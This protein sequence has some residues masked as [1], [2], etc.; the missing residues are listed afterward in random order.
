MS[1]LRVAILAAGK[2]TRMKS[3]HPKV[4]FP[5]CGVPMVQFVLWEA[6]QLS[7]LKPMVVIGYQ[8]EQVAA[9][10]GEQ[11]EYVWQREQLGT[12]D[13]VKKVCAELP[14]FS[15]DLLVL[16]GDTPFISAAS[17]RAMLEVHR[18]QRAAATVLTAELPDPTGY[19]RILRSPEGVL[20]GIVEEKDASPDQK[21]IREVN[22][23]IYCF[24]VPQLRPALAA[25]QPQ[26]T[27]GEYYLTDVIGF[28]AAAGQA[29][30]TVKSEHPEE[31]MGPNDRKALA[32]TE[33]K[34]RQKILDRIME[35]GVTV[36]DPA[37]TYIDPRVTI[38]RDTTLYPGVILMGETKIGANC[39][40]GPY[41]QI[42][43]SV[44]GE[45]SH[46]YFSILTDVT[47]GKKVEV[48]PYAHL[49]PGTKVAD[50]GKVGGFVEI[51]NSTVGMNSKVP[52]LSYIGDTTIGAGVNIGAGTITCN[53]DGDK[54]WPTVIEDGAFI[55]SNT[56][57]V[58]PVRVGEQALVGAGS[59]ITREVPAYSVTV[60]RAHQTSKVMPPVF[61][62]ETVAGE[63]V[64][65]VM[66]DCP[67]PEVRLY[68]STDGQEPTEESLS[69]QG[70]LCLEEGTVLKAKA[71]KDGWLPSKTRILKVGE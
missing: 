70:Q 57:L 67:T 46:V 1:E 39:R 17:L 7:P 12:G 16:Y 43:S 6:A 42:T 53:Y 68:Y 28:L 58:A 50:Q 49:R 9:A 56:N 14:E 44:V 26:N 3:D 27:Q 69:Y 71:F 63:K 60:A 13:A 40:I 18:S 35:A 29:L 41:T 62:V 8:G 37:N 54:K 65:R 24:S 4:L 51:K 25:L 61:H 23:G 5:L 52:H 36:I 33:A 21:S 30:A 2:G 66:I 20:T 55:G 47:L 11:A 32:R 45:G 10:L 31:I 19:G 64:Y 59:T 15:G 38:G 48:G 22:T 34:M